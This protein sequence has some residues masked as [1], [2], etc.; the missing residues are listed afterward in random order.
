[1]NVCDQKG[2]GLEG[3]AFSEDITSKLIGED[4]WDVLLATDSTTVRADAGKSCQPHSTRKQVYRL[5]QP[6]PRLQ[7][8]DVPYMHMSEVAAAAEASIEAYEFMH[9]TTPTFTHIFLPPAHNTPK[10]MYPTGK[11]QQV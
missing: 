5:Y 6:A 1:M 10:T 7:V 8:K 9:P 4:F 2:V 11:L 3:E